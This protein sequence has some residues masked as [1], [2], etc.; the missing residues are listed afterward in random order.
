MTGRYPGKWEVLN[1][2]N[3]TKKAELFTF[4][5]IS[6]QVVEGLLLRGAQARAVH[7]RALDLGLQIRGLPHYR[8]N[9]GRGLLKGVVT[10]RGEC[11]VQPAI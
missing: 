9:P 2:S 11:A 10:W 3:T 8:G 7:P 6:A 1:T 4:V 5:E